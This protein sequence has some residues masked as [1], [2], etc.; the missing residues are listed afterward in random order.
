[1]VQSWRSYDMTSKTAQAGYPLIVSNGYYLDMLTTAGKHYEADPTEPT[2][3]LQSDD[4]TKKT[5]D[6]VKLS[7]EEKTRFIGGE[8]AMWCELVTDEMID[9]RIWPRSAA[10]AERYWSPGSVRDLDDMY[11]RL[12]VVDNE[13]SILGLRQHENSQRMVS[14]LVPAQNRVVNTFLAAAR[15]APYWSH[16]HNFRNGNKTGEPLQQFNEL[17][18]AATP[19]AL[20]ARSTELDVKRFIAD[21]AKDPVIAHRIRTQ[22]EQWR[23]NNEEFKQ[24][25]QISP[26][27]SD[28]I[29]RSQDLHD[30]SVAGLE[31]LDL[32]E[33]G[34][35][36]AEAWCSKQKELLARQDAYD[37]ATASF[38]AVSS[39]PQPPS[40][41]LLAIHP[42]VR[43]LVEAAQKSVVPFQA[44]H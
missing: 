42:A 1:L 33:K 22:L 3:N 5:S 17:A 9:A 39:K 23:D 40:D 19:D 34:S 43:L 4:R 31:A 6:P 2:D 8:A 21:G 41:L 36:P 25:L 16:N 15:P 44:T 14:R 27:F 29:P 13:L 7:P 24:L 10:I 38:D 20:C 32:L 18:D 28:A 12:I 26:I 37:A 11:R 35:S 30:L